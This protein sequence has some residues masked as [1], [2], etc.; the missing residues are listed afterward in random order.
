[1]VE[2]RGERAEPVTLG[3][4]ESAPTLFTLDATDKRQAAMLNETG[5]CNS[6]SNPTAQGEAA[7]L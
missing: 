5:C 4:V 3:V 1:V 7:V 2:Y 6:C